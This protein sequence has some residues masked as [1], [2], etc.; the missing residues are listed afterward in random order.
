MRWCLLGLLCL[1]RAHGVQAACGEALAE[2]HRAVAAEAQALLMTEQTVRAAQAERLSREAALRAALLAHRP[3]DYPRELVRR[4]DALRR[5]EVERKLEMLEWL[6]AQHKESRRH[7]E[8]GYQL[9]NAQLAD[10][11]AAFQAQTLSADD[12][13]GVRERY[14]QALQMYRQGIQR[15]RTGMDLYAQ[16]LDAYGAR[17]LLL[18]TQGFAHQQLWEVLIGQL[19]QGDFL[20]DVLV[21]LTANAIRSPPPAVPPSRRRSPAVEIRQ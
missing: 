14:R 6:R 3:R 17:F 19:E 9:L 15:Y 4:V 5:P 2:T 16:A 7:W 21:P 18:Y 1:A 11:R 10:A 13:C 12:Y 20:H 8:H